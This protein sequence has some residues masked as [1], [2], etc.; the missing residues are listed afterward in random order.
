MFQKIP[1]SSTSLLKEIVS[2]SRVLG[3]VQGGGYKAPLGTA[4]RSS[5]WF[6][7]EP[8]TAS[9]L[10]DQSG[11]RSLIADTYVPDWGICLLQQVQWM[12]EEPSLCL[13]S[14][15]QFYLT[16]NGLLWAMFAIQPIKTHV[17]IT[18]NYISNMSRRWLIV[19]LAAVGSGG[20]NRSRLGPVLSCL[21]T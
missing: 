10:V 14:N 15:L 11:S 7:A 19:W 18:L 3:T 1:G 13:Y 5:S 12:L 20:D 9:C 2:V 16:K 17:V 6:P 4:I 8:P 21:K